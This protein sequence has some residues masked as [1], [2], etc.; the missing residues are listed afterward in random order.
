[1]VFIVR[2]IVVDI[3]G[4]LIVIE[5]WVFVLM[6]VKMDILGVFVIKVRYMKG[7]YIFFRLFIVYKFINV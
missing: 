6:D 4:L 7:K 3:V 5:K 1:M 2:R